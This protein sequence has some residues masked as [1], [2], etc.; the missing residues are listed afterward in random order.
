MAYQKFEF[1]GVVNEEH[2]TFF[3]KYGFVH[4]TNFLSPQQV[5]EILSSAQKVET[6][7]L[8]AD[9]QLVNGTPI[10]YGK[11]ENGNTIVHRFAFLNQY[12][13]AVHHLVSG[14]SFENLKLLLPDP[15]NARVGLDEKDGVV[16]NHYVNTAGSNFLEMGWHTDGARDLFYG[17]RVQP[18]LNV[19][20]Y[21][22]DSPKTKGGLR[23][24]P[25]SHKQGWWNLL[26]RKRYFLDHTEDD[27][28]VAIEAKAGDLVIHH[29]SIWHRVAASSFVGSESRRRVMYTPIV[30]GKYIPKTSTSKTPFYHRFGGLVGR[31][32]NPVDIPSPERWIL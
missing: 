13:P 18:M 32:K 16:L 20:V 26:F 7:W 15:Y 21:L 25:G 2:K 19:G 30:T 31:R 24:L 6:D 27:N 1:N 9:I 10:K 14:K 12:S 17:L 4:F 3:N 28:E 22:D 5:Q 11:D 23:V 29:G 8:A